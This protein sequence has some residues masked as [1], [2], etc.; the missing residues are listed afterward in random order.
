M[1]GSEF[2]KRRASFLLQKNKNN[3][4]RNRELLWSFCPVKIL[5]IYFELFH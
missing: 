3:E 5:K 1:I 2:R 4:G